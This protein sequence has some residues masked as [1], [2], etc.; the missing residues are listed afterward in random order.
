MSQ[1]PRPESLPE[2][3][4]NC[5]QCRHHRI[6]HDVNFPYA[7]QAIGFKSRQLPCRQVLADSGLPCQYFAPRRRGDHQSG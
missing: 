1:P 5:M 4:P 3:L 2:S 6:T 7:C